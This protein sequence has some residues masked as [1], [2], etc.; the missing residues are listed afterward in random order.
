MAR[1]VVVRFCRR[2]WVAVGACWGRR[3]GERWWGRRGRRGRGEMAEILWNWL[4]N[5]RKRDGKRRVL[6]RKNEYHVHAMYCLPYKCFLCFLFVC[7]S[8]SH[9]PYHHT[10][11]KRRPNARQPKAHQAHEKGVRQQVTLI[12]LL[13][14]CLYIHLQKKKLY[15]TSIHGPGRIALA[16][17]HGSGEATHEDP[18]LAD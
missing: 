10:S 4:I 14:P 1:L 13:F 16:L 11:L 7:V 17:T 8:T 9:P 3:R 2:L 5:G 6:I 18:S 15:S 12:C